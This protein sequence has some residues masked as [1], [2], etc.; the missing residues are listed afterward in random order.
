MFMKN[1]IRTLFYLFLFSTVV[2]FAQTPEQRAKII[3]SYDLNALN[4]LAIE[5]ETTYQ[6]NKSRAYELAFQNN[7]PLKFKSQ[8]G[9]FSE[10]QGVDEFGNPIYYQT[11]NRG[12]TRTINAHH[13]NTSGSLGLD[14]NGQNMTAGVWDGDAIR[15]THQEFQGRA[16][17][18]DGVAFTT[19]NDNSDHGT[20][21]AGT[22]IA[23]G[24]NINVK[25]A[26][27]QGNVWGND[28]NSDISE[29][30]SQAA[31]GLLVSNHSYG[32]NAE[33]LSAWQFGAY[34]STSRFFDQVAFNA[35]FLQI[36]KS[37]GND[38][39]TPGY[40]G[41]GGYD[42]LTAASLSKNVLTVGAVE[43]V[44]N[45]VGPSSVVMSTFSSYGPAD[46][47]RVKPDIVAKGV[48]V[49]STSSFS[50]TATVSK[51]GTSMS[52]P[53]AAS[54][55]LL[56][57]QYYNELNGNFMRAA[58]ARG[59]VIHTAREAGLQP[60]PDASFGWGLMDVR[61]AALMIAGNENTS[62]IEERSLAQG[63]TYSFDVVSDGVNELIATICWTD[64]AGNVVN[65]GTVDVQTPVL[66]NDLDLRISKNG[67]EFL[68]WKLSA[69]AFASAATKGDNTVDN[70][71]KVQ[72][73]GAVG[74][75]TITVSHKGTLQGNNQNYSI[76]VSGIDESLNLKNNDKLNYSI[77]PNP[78]KEKFYVNFDDTVVGKTEL[79]LF[80]VNGRRIWTDTYEPFSGIQSF[81]MQGLENGVYILTI[82]TDG[83]IKNHKIVK[84]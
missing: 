25:G 5:L 54:G 69:T 19:Y 12:A 40:S 1:N 78:V 58:T 31:E 34:N 43:Q 59:L 32:P 66:V 9:S 45:Y 20:H 41:K 13:I 57:Q 21:V 24:I 50:N 83:I 38:R 70:V 29:L 42:L 82:N 7:W 48:G 61:A 28:W 17:N 67:E 81:N 74:T 2:V 55:V 63:Q 23:A 37:A 56:L 33:F 16:I 47:G 44:N 53:S 46:D 39:T 27:F 11:D 36:V 73:P 18:K 10:L 22:I 14:I 62:I 8:D 51:D 72:V 79:S 3:Y 35:P 49:L 4:Q 84:N 15:T 64:P 71:E 60:G 6:Q 65:T 26:A 80:D 52:S 77:Y 68:P 30:A 75:Y 76:L